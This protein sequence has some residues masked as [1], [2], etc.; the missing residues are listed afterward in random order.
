MEEKA[1]LPSFVHTTIGRCLRQL[2]EAVTFDRAGIWLY[3]KGALTL[4]GNYFPPMPGITSVAS[5]PPESIFYQVARNAE[6]LV[7]RD[8]QAER[9][10][11]SSERPRL[12]WKMPSIQLRYCL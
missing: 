1:S 9:L 11:H 4:Q 6:A 2:R 10:L 12:P 5:L 7:V 3:S 8:T